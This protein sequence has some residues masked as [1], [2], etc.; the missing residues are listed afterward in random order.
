MKVFEISFILR[1]VTDERTDGRTDRQTDSFLVARPP[2]F[3]AAP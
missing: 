1:S 2:V 3:Y